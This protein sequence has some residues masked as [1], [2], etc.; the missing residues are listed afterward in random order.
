MNGVR[1][2]TKSEAQVGPAIVSEAVLAKIGLRPP[3]PPGAPWLFG[4][5]Y[6]G[7]TNYRTLVSFNFPYEKDTAYDAYDDGILPT[8]QSNWRVKAT[9]ETVHIN[10]YSGY[11]RGSDNQQANFIRCVI[12][13]SGNPIRDFTVG[14]YSSLG[15]TK[16]EFAWIQGLVIMTLGIRLPDI[17]PTIKRHIQVRFILLLLAFCGDQ[18]WAVQE[19]VLTKTL[20]RYN[21]LLMFV[22]GNGI[23]SDF[24]VIYLIWTDAIASV[25]HLGI[26]PAIPTLV[27]ALCFTHSDK[28]VLGLT[29]VD[30]EAQVEAYLNA[31]YI[32]NLIS[33]SPTSMNLWTRFPLLPDDPPTWLVAREL[34]WFF[35]LSIGITIALVLYKLLLLAHDF[36]HP[37][38]PPELQA[39]TTCLTHPRQPWQA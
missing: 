30:M 10:G 25:H 21:L 22:L 2:S 39:T 37:P 1:S 3:D 28:L 12:A 34:S 31:F 19:W 9:N 18:F 11:Y 5:T 13:M 36:I 6:A 27:Y 8:N 14:L 24:L 32:R 38:N 7:R 35:A 17:F 23:R 29:S 33:F 20:V 4:L 16:D 26:P 15:H